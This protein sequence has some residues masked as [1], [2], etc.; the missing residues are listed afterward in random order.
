MRK[1]IGG[2]TNGHGLKDEDFNRASSYDRSFKSI[3]RKQDPRFGEV[4]IVRNQATKETVVVK[5]K[6]FNDKNE[7]AKAILVIRSKLQ[8]QNP[9]SL[10]L[11]DYSVSKQ[12]EL[13]STIYI[14]KQFYEF[15][16]SDLRHQFTLRTSSRT[17]F[18]AAELTDIALRVA[19]ADTSGMHGDIS[20]V[21]ILFD[22]TNNLVKLVDKSDEAPSTTRTITLQKNKIISNQPLYQS[23]K[24]YSNLKNS[25]LQFDID[26]DKEDAFS[27]G[28]L[29]LELGNLRPINNIYDS[30]KR[31]VDSS[32]LAKHLSDFRAAFASSPTIVALVEGLIRLEEAQRLGL[33][34]LITTLETQEKHNG[35]MP[36][37]TL[38]VNSAN[39]QAAPA[40][41]IL[42]NGHVEQRVTRIDTT[43]TTTPLST[44]NMPSIYN[45][46][47]LATNAYYKK[48]EL[49]P[50]TITTASKDYKYTP[51][52]VVNAPKSQISVSRTD[53]TA[54]PTDL[55]LPGAEVTGNASNN[56]T[57]VT[58]TLYNTQKIVSSP[59]VEY[60]RSYTNV[61]STYISNPPYT[62]YAPISSKVVLE[63]EFRREVVTAVPVTH[64]GYSQLSYFPV[65]T[66]TPSQGY[67]QSSFQQ[68]HGTFPMPSSYSGL[69]NFPTTVRKSYTRKSVSMTPLTRV[70]AYP[71]A[72]SVVYSQ[73][74]P[75]SYEAAKPLNMAYPAHTLGEARTPPPR[76]SRSNL[77]SY[78][79]NNFNTEFLAHPSGAYITSAQPYDSAVNS[80]P[81]IVY[82]TPNLY[83]SAVQSDHYYVQ[84]LPGQ[85]YHPTNLIPTPNGVA[86]R[87]YMANSATGFQPT[88][89]SAQ[90]Q[91]SHHSVVKNAPSDYTMPS[92]NLPYY[93]PTF[94]ATTVSNSAKNIKV[95][96][97]TN[98]P[99]HYVTESSAIDYSR[100][101]SSNASQARIVT[102]SNS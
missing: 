14:L 2:T 97:V 94:V 69:A 10:K 37:Y 39:F 93:S 77:Q 72:S 71:T 19:K 70:S 18:T 41:T 34:E 7:I 20:P 45:G 67:A 1:L 64:S 84:T 82:E 49:P 56:A 28:L 40:T 74:I 13:C 101:I 98:L 55:K 91:V 88:Y 99:M 50:V 46:I 57:Q 31:L 54:L 60:S 66:E 73:N 43:V 12:T 6:K 95:P 53:L 65:A 85:S 5:E 9:Y 21:N 42:P 58:Q 83:P 81:Q 25:N 75:L 44:P 32:V 17:L 52:V 35:L 36:P 87:D 89:I 38:P 68:P 4:S 30:A 15:F 27:L 23:P 86:L 26:G 51:P 29:L 22:K 3:S 48:P 62:S 96:S 76:I 80:Q 79:T 11:L 61:P 24:M 63:P 100:P 102:M 47:N 59:T 33:R 16:E 92:N 8:N 90:P 78:Q